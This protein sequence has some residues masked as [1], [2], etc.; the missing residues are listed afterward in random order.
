MRNSRAPTA[1]ELK[2][3][4]RGFTELKNTQL[5]RAMDAITDSTTH[6]RILLNPNIHH[7]AHAGV[8]KQQLFVPITALYG[9]EEIAAIIAFAEFQHDTMGDNKSEA[10]AQAELEAIIAT[11]KPPFNAYHPQHGNFK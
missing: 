7:G 8:L 2:L 4:M 6:V 1:G 5:N 11:L 9:P 10:E 3:I